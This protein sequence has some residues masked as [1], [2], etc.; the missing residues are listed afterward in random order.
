MIAWAQEAFHFLYNV[1]GLI[2]WGGLW[3]VTFVIFAETGL[4][5]G[6]FLP[7]DSLL[8]VAGIFARAREL[9]LPWLLVLPCLAAILGNQTGY[10]LGLRLEHS[11]MNWPDSLFFKKRHLVMTHEFYAKY[12]A[13]T[14]FLARFVPIVRT[15]APLVG[16]IGE[17][18]YAP[19]LLYTVA[20]AVAWVC[21][22]V[23]AGYSLASL[24]P[25]IEKKIHAVIVV[26][27]FLSILPG[28]VE[29]FRARRRRQ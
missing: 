8:V 11:M 3:L 21:G 23:L 29:F 25:D 12:G 16:G 10:F 15:F 19:F 2:E 5:F 1:H 28:I 24:V 9:P 20:G 27:V 17:M 18:G 7:G 26:V 4:F 14:I 22:L 13:K 6:F